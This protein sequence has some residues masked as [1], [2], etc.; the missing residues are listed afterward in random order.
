M[1]VCENQLQES[2]PIVSILPSSIIKEGMIVLSIKT[3]F[4]GS[5]SQEFS[6]HRKCLT[7]AC[8]AATPLVWSALEEAWVDACKER[9]NPEYFH[10]TDA[11][12]LKENFKGWTRASCDYLID[13][14][15]DVLGRFAH[16]GFWSFACTVD[17][18]AHS[19][20]SKL[21]SLPSAARLCARIVYPAMLDWY[22]K[23][24]NGKLRNID[25]VFDRNEPFMRHLRPDWES[26]KFRQHH[27]SWK[28]VRSMISAQMRLTPALQMTDMIAWSK[29][30]LESGS[31]KENDSFYGTALK[32]FRITNALS[33]VVDQEWLLKHALH[34]EGYETINPQRN[35]RKSR[36]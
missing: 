13:G 29:N 31:T 5:R 23:L 3:F 16:R 34:E 14:L 27:P 1:E 22:G 8:L 24:S 7:L 15:I 9:G 19:R 33:A 32:A 12:S 20:V 36:P 6:K 10:M 35:N 30:R 26:K 21:K 4:D 2:S 28:I 18:D 11:I 25:L 17:L